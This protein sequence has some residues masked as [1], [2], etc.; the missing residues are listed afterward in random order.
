[1][2]LRRAAPMTSPATPSSTV[3][4][5][6]ANMR[7]G[8]ASATVRPAS[9]TQ[10]SELLHNLPQDC[11]PAF[12]EE[13]SAATT[14]L[15]NF[16]AETPFSQADATAR[17]VRFGSREILRALEYCNAV[18]ERSPCCT[19]C[20]EAFRDRERHACISVNMH[21]DATIKTACFRPLDGRRTR[22]CSTLLS[23]DTHVR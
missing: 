12:Q 6:C 11:C 15:R 18:Q 5:S 1:M 13:H 16:A 20:S 10:G 22:S 14:S 23:T 7:C 4:R 2:R 3:S 19:R 21:A 17:P 9:T 8:R